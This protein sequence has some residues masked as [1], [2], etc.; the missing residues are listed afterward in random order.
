[1]PLEPF[2]SNNE[3]EL[4]PESRQEAILTNYARYEEQPWKGREGGQG[5]DAGTAIK[6]LLIGI[7]IGAG[8]ALFLTPANGRE[9]RSALG[10]GYRRTVDGLSRGTLEL[11]QRGSNLLSFARGKGALRSQQG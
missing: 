9:M 2:L 1:V 4:S 5:A 3:P 7:G 10:R 8:A 6:W 11:R